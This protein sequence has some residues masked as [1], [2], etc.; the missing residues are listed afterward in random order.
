MQVYR[1]DY[2]VDGTTGFLANADDELSEK[3]DALI[4]QPELRRTM[5]K[6]AAAHAQKFDWDGIA[7]NWQD[8]LEQAVAKRQKDRSRYRRSL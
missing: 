1:P 8:A 5:A 6:A 7:K 2:V 4:R 3:L